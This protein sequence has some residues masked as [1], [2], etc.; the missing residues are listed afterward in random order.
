MSTRGAGSAG[1]WCT[2]RVC[3]RVGTRVGYVHRVYSHTQPFSAVFSRILTVF[4][5]ILSRIQPYSAVFSRSHSHAR[6]IILA[7]GIYSCTRYYSGTLSYYSCFTLAEPP[8]SP[9]SK[10]GIN[11]GY[12]KPLWQQCYTVLHVLHLFVKRCYSLFRKT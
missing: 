8:G 7:R 1:R 9:F 10:T 11:S 4:S 2:R 3:T 12:R 5:R 6:G